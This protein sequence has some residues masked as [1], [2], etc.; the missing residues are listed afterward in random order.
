M[1]MV[2]EDRELANLEQ[3]QNRLLASLFKWAQENKVAAKDWV[4]GGWS[5]SSDKVNFGIRLAGAPIELP[6]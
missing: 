4:Q 6:G 2:L 5:R 3:V 1:A